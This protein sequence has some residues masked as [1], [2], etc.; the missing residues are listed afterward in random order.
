MINYLALFLADEPIGNL[1]EKSGY[2]VM[3]I[4]EKL[5][6]VGSFI[7]AV[8][9]NPGIGDGAKRM[10]MLGHGRTAREEKKK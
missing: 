5:H 4:L 8:T 7:I 1:G 2:L 9:H 10:I 3:D 6:D